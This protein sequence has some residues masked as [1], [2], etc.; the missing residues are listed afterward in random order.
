MAGDVITIPVDAPPFICSDLLR[1]VDLEAASEG[2]VLET[3]EE[4]ISEGEMTEGDALRFIDDFPESDRDYLL[5]YC[6]DHC[7]AGSCAMKGFGV[8]LAGINPAATS[9]SEADQ[10]KLEFFCTVDTVRACGKMSMG[11]PI[12]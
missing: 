4:R 8:E 2:H 10:A 3:L 9:L 1:V 5:G 6:R 7:S 11:I 12:F